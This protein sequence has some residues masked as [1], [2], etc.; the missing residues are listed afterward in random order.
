MPS[1][2]HDVA[3]CIVHN[4]NDATTRYV[5]YYDDVKNVDYTLSEITYFNNASPGLYLGSR[6]ATA[7]FIGTMRDF[8]M[9][10]TIVDN[11][12]INTYLEG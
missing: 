3:I 9:Y 6:D 4:A 12:T 2:N 10:N 7:S 5:I 11:D 1:G 8:V